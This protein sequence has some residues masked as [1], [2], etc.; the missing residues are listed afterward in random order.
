MAFLFLLLFFMYIFPA[1]FLGVPVIRTTPIFATILLV[2][3]IILWSIH[4]Y[5]I[6]K[7]ISLPN[8]LA[9]KHL[10]VQENGKP[11]QAKIL[12]SAD[13]GFLEE[14]T[15]KNYWSAFQT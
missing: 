10:R 2:L 5:K 8:K 4:T 13:S 7:F 11:V 14:D 15:E 12:A 1:F 3:G 6:S 9:R